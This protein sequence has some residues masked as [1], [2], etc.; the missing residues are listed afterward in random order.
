M[1]A[2]VR[3]GN[4]KSGTGPDILIFGSGN[5]IAQL[6]AE[7]LIDQYMMVMN[8]VVLGNGRT[9]FEGIKEPQDLK[10][11]NTRV[12]KNGKVLLQFEAA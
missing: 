6:A 10:L 7:K 4:I 9:M 3:Y 1:P 12:F 11:A 2:W 8:P 5:L